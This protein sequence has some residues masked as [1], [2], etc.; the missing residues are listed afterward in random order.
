M[1]FANLSPHRW[2]KI[3]YFFIMFMLTNELFIE[4]F[5]KYFILFN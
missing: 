3:S 5:Q 4:L 1:Q 2:Q